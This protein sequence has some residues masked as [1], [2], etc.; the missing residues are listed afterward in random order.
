M[1]D[2]RVEDRNCHLTV[3]TGSEI[4]IVRR[5]LIQNMSGINLQP[6]V[7]WLRTATGERT[8][9]HG[10]SKMEL[11]IGRLKMSHNMVVADIKD[12]CILGTDFLTPHECVVDLKDGVLTI[13]GEQVP[14]QK[15]RQMTI[16]TCCRVT[17]EN[18]VDLPPLSET[19]IGA[20]IQNR[21]NS[22]VW[23]IL[24]PKEDSLCSFDGLLIGRALVNTGTN[25]IPVCLL[26]LTRLPKRIKSGTQI[27]MCSAVE[28][29]VAEMCCACEGSKK[30]GVSVMIVKCIVLVKVVK[31]TVRL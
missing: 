18:N 16:P 24:E 17:L 8:P 15:S 9:I 11:V 26:N 6:Q 25:N 2:G 27:A 5:D 19:V 28:S 29:V 1:V 7:G 22:M 23:G 4:S 13:K 3:D 20:S 21:P 31:K 12:E 14:L 30:N 10:W